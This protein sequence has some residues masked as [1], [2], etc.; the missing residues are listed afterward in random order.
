MAVSPLMRTAAASSPESRPTSR[1]D[2]SAD[3]FLLSSATTSS[4]SPGGILHAQPPPCANRVSRTRCSVAVT[5][6]TL[7]I[8]E[9]CRSSDHYPQCRRRVVGVDGSGL[10]GGGV[11]WARDGRECRPPPAVG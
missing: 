3:T 6:S 10:H 9:Y 8:A 4:S 11:G 1:S 7:G 5:P 2:V